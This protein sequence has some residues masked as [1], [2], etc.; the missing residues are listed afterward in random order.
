MN[1]EKSSK[2]S[3]KIKSNKELVI[4]DGTKE[5]SEEDEYGEDHEA[6]LI[7]PAK[8]VSDTKAA[9]KF[10]ETYEPEVVDI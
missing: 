1:S 2:T 5:K 6:I 3:E 10:Y 9:R 7:N 8:V 4:N